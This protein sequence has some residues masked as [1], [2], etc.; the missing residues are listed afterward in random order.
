MCVCDGHIDQRYSFSNSGNCVDIAA[1]GQVYTTIWRG[2]DY[3]TFG[4]TSAAAPVVAGVAALVISANP[5]LTV[6]RCRTL[7]NDRR[8]TADRQGGIPAMAG[9]RQRL[10]GR[11]HGTSRNRGYVG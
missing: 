11:Q 4:G 6:H 1:P 8:M 5:S 7:S 2:W 9:T 10:P 3:S